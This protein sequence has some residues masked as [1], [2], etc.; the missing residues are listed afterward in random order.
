MRFTSVA[1]CLLLIAG[2]VLAQGDRGTITGAVSDPAGAV[3]AAAPIEARNVDTGA[4]YAAASSE[5]GN[6]RF[7]SCPPATTR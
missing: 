6:S 4:L 1:L 2:T 7:R 3:V 5:T